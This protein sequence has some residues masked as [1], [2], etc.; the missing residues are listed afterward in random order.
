[1]GEGLEGRT[2]TGFVVRH[3][4]CCHPNNILP[5]TLHYLQE[6]LQHKSYLGLI[7]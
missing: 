7:G 4:Q 5:R 1:M 6:M 2:M 3:M